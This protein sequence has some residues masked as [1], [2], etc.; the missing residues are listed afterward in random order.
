MD[1]I[2]SMQWFFKM[3]FEITTQIS[4]GKYFFSQFHLTTLA[5]IGSTVH[6]QLKSASV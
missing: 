4:L 5:N 2:I 3:K 1:M 6:A